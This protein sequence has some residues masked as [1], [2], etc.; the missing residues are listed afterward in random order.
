MFVDHTHRSFHKDKSELVMD[1]F[2]ITIAKKG[3]DIPSSW[4][5]EAEKW[6]NEMLNV[7]LFSLER[8]GR[9]KNLHIQGACDVFAERGDHVCT[10]MKNS[11]KERLCIA[12]GEGASLT[13][14]RHP[15]RLYLYGYCMKDRGAPHFNNFRF[16]L[17]RGELES[18]MQSY[19][20]A[21]T[22]YEKN[23]ERICSSNVLTHA[24]KFYQEFIAPIRPAPSLFA[25]LKWMLQSGKYALN[26]SLFLRPFDQEALETAWQ[27]ACDPANGSC[28]DIATMLYRQSPV[29]RD[30]DLM[31]A[32]RSLDSII[33]EVRQLREEPR[34][35]WDLP[36]SSTG[37]GGLF[38]APVPC[39]ADAPCVWDMPSGEQRRRHADTA[40]RGCPVEASSPLRLSTVPTLEFDGSLFSY[41]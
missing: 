2:S 39:M 37:G 11:I 27:L 30:S 12:Y 14:K 21:Q 26:G 10:D 8:G 7:A 19:D 35:T 13:V 20:T 17:G 36:R 15:N 22:R 38:A 40:Q 25:V 5:V 31:Y 3:T 6:A 41:E 16:G 9:A 32:D 18:C 1:T 34:D 28:D 24:H 23:K 33:E 4:F 29:Y